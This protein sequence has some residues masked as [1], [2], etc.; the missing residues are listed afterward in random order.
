M[1]TRAG[2]TGGASPAGKAQ[3]GES[4]GD[5]RPRR[6]RAPAAA[7]SQGQSTG[8]G[9]VAVPIVPEGKPDRERLEQ[10]VADGF[11][12]VRLRLDN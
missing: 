6:D 1:T 7:H 10:A 12:I 9:F 2:T 4:R 5:P 3:G 11:A 8:E